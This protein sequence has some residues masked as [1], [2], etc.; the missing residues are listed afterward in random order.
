MRGTDPCKGPCKAVTGPCN[1]ISTKKWPY[2]ILYPFVSSYG[3]GPPVPKFP[4]IFQCINPVPQEFHLEM[5]CRRLP[6]LGVG[7]ASPVGQKYMI[8]PN[9]PM[10]FDM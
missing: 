9:C 6:I 8:L 5:R 1:E 3:T 2:I 10:L 4:P 7:K